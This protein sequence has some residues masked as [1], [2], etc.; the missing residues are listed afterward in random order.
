MAAMAAAAQTMISIDFPDGCIVSYDRVRRAMILTLC[1]GG[2]M[3]CGAAIPARPNPPVTRN[4]AVKNADGTVTE[5]AVVVEEVLNPVSRSAFV[6]KLG[7]NKAPIIGSD[8]WNRRYIHLEENTLSYHVDENSPPKGVIH[9][10]PG[11]EVD[12]IQANDRARKDRQE[13]G[14]NPGVAGLMTMPIGQ[15]MD[16]RSTPVGKPNCV[17]LHVPAN[18]GNM[19]NSV[20]GHSAM[21]LAMSGVRDIK[22]NA[23]R[24][25]YFSFD[26]LDEAQEFA[27]AIGNNI[28]CLVNQNKLGD[29]S[30]SANAMRNGNFSQL[31]DAMA[32]AHSVQK[33]QALITSPDTS[34]EWYKVSLNSSLPPDVIYERL[35]I[36]YDTLASFNVHPSY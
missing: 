9:L 17:E 27:S 31:N 19:M 34:L 14:H 22:K 15:M 11:C 24:T 33:N 26:S 35:M 20:M 2:V 36:F 16:T 4:V 12:V 29:K 10:S 1:N 5:Q 25:Y 30:I 13:G 8:I 32:M 6:N 28:K 3:S 21:S 7:F 18:V 23:A